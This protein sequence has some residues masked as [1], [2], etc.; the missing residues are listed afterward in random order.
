MATLK[1]LTINPMSRVHG[2]LGVHAVPRDPRPQPA[3]RR[4]ERPA[5]PQVPPLGHLY[6]TGPGGV[7][8]FYLE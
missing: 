8:I 1:D 3:R 2:E 5:E 6:L 7:L 4:A